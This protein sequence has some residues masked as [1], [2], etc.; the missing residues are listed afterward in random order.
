L[1][2]GLVLLKMGTDRGPKATHAH[3]P[4]LL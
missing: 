1:A 4:A 3:D 2:I